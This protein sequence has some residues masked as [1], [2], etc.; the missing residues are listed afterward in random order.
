MPSC[1]RNGTVRWQNDLMRLYTIKISPY[2]NTMSI[3]F[4]KDGEKKMCDIMTD[5]ELITVTIDRYTDLQRIK[6]A[7]GEH[8][9]P[10]LEYQIKVTVAKLASMGVSIEDITL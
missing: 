10:E 7:N 8:E 6:R 4:I 3:I 2:N 9:N 1:C 5:K